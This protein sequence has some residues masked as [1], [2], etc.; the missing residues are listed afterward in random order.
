MVN[1]SVRWNF[2]DFFFVLKYA[3]KIEFKNPIKIIIN[4]NPRGHCDKDHEPLS[5]IHSSPK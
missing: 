4:R 2:A 3:I 1:P 5:G